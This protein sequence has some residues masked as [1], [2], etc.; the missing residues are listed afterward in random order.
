MRGALGQV[1]ETG[2][3]FQFGAARIHEREVDGR[4]AGMRRTLARIGEESRLRKLLPQNPLCLARPEGIED[5]QAI[6]ERR[7]QRDG[8]GKTI[9]GVAMQIAA[10]LPIDRR[11]VTLA[12][13][14]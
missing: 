7:R 6:A 8:L 4:A 10:R 14:A 5:L 3:H 9:G 1:I 13:E 11:P 12:E 2:A